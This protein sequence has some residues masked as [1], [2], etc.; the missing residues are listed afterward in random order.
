MD[1]PVLVYSI[2]VLKRQ[3]KGISM[4][5]LIEM[6]R[7]LESA[8]LIYRDYEP[9]VPSQVTYGLTERIKEL[10]EVLVQLNTLAQHRYK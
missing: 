2:G 10:D 1:Q 7:M 4:K 8:G 6:L 5:V 9:T 3:V